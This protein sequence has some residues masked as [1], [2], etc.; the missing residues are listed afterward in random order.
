MA[1]HSGEQGVIGP[2]HHYA[3]LMAVRKRSQRRLEKSD[4]NLTRRLSGN[5]AAHA[6]AHQCP[7]LLQRYVTVPAIQRK[8]IDC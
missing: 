5:V 2:I 3:D 4:H 1:L 8:R 6:A 7:A